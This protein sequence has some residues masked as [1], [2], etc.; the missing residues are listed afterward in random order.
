MKISPTDI[1]KE[2]IE[3]MLYEDNELIVYKDGEISTRQQGSFGHH[4]DQIIY[5]TPLGYH[6]WS[7][8][9]DTWGLL[10]SEGQFILSEV[11]PDILQDFID[12]VIIPDIEDKIACSE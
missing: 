11:D 8:T 6:W 2:I 5:S 12:E 9:L 3:H 7:L 1:A 10:N 4:E